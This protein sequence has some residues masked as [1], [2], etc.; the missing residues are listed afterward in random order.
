MRAKRPRAH[1]RKVDE[2]TRRGRALSVSHA[3]P[4]AITCR[5][6]RRGDISD[7]ARRDEEVAGFIIVGV[8]NI[9]PPDGELPMPV[10]GTE[11]DLG[12]GEPVIVNCIGRAQQ[13]QG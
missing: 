13:R 11:S 9:P 8:E 10:I 3:H 1:R 6:A 5:R 2:A 12:V 4:H 7:P